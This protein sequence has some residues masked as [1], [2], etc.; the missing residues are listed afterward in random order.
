MGKKESKKPGIFERFVTRPIKYAQYKVVYFF[1]Y[2][3]IWLIQFW[4]YIKEKTYEFSYK[5]SPQ[6]ARNWNWLFPTKSEDLKGFNKKTFGKK[7][8]GDIENDKYRIFYEYDVPFPAFSDPGVKSDDPVENL[9]LLK[10]DKLDTWYSLKSDWAKDKTISKG[11]TNPYDTESSGSGSG[12]GVSSIEEKA[13]NKESE[14][15]LKE[16]VLDEEAIEEDENDEK[17]EEDAIDEEDEEEAIDEEEALEQRQEKAREETDDIIEPLEEEPEEEDE[18]VIEETEEELEAEIDEIIEDELAEIEEDNINK[19]KEIT[20]KQSKNKKSIDDKLEK[21]LNIKLIKIYNIQPEIE[22]R[23]N[24]TAIKLYKKIRDDVIYNAKTII[25]E[26]QKTSNIERS[27]KLSKLFDKNARNILNIAEI[28]KLTKY[29]TD[30]DLMYAMKDLVEN[31]IKLIEI[32][33]H[34]SNVSSNFTTEQYKDTNQKVIGDIQAIEIGMHD[35]KKLSDRTIDSKNSTTR[36]VTYNIIKNDANKM[37]NAVKKLK[38]KKISE[39]LHSDLDVIVDTLNMYNTIIKK[40]RDNEK[41]VRNISI[42]MKNNDDTVSGDV[43]STNFSDLKEVKEL[44]DEEFK[45]MKME[46]VMETDIGVKDGEAIAL[47]NNNFDECYKVCN[48][49]DKCVGFSVVTEVGTD[50]STCYI[51][52]NQNQLH[53]VPT[54][55]V[56]DVLH[57]SNQNNVGYLQG[58]KNPNIYFAKKHYNKF[59]TNGAYFLTNSRANLKDGNTLEQLE[60]NIDKDKN[61][62]FYLNAN[63]LVPYVDLKEMFSYGDI[64]GNWV[65]LFTKNSTKTNGLYRVPMYISKEGRLYTSNKKYVDAT[66]EIKQFLED[67]NGLMFIKNNSLYF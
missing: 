44:T 15:A 54:N 51:A 32:L 53:Y 21:E 9:K 29:T 35:I 4:R 31:Y 27:N 55:N 11:Y 60:I 42:D 46:Y 52:E 47:K 39:T 2:I 33:D 64:K 30:L 13:F 1:Y 25:K 14:E 5:N 18:D 50:R 34:I 56:F 22:G 40:V 48:N 16:E 23:D 38:G 8:Q 58:L 62:R 45:Q 65:Y 63:E 3:T 10:K 43:A 6:F 24:E 49:K 66:T 61:V 57:L 17:D 41:I 26:I 59:V 37:I 7:T 19:V 12:S 67:K 20:K 36:E 28:V